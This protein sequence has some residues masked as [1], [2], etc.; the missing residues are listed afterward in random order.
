MK[1][2]IADHH[3]VFRPKAKTMKTIYD[4]RNDT[5]FVRFTETAI[6]E[7]EEISPGLILD[8][9]VDGRIVALEFL[10]ASKKI[11]GEATLKDSQPEPITRHGLS[12]PRSPDELVDIVHPESVRRIVRPAFVDTREDVVV[13][14][15]LAVGVDIDHGAVDLEQRDHLLDMRVDDEGVGLARRLVDVRTFGRDPVVLEIAPLAFEH[16]AVHRQRMAVAR[17]HAGF[18]HLEQVHP[19]AARG[20]HQE[21]AEPD[22][23]LD[24]H[25]DALVGRNGVR[26]DEFRRRFLRLR[27]PVG[28][29]FVVSLGGLLRLAHPKLPKSSR[30]ERSGEPGPTPHP[31]RHGSRIAADAASGTTPRRIESVTRPDT[32]RRPRG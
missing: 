4:E 27:V 32:P 22:V 24:R 31:R 15:R 7:S 28:L 11:A 26:D 17:Q 10:N 6:L 14:G 2:R 25:P 5:L 8:Y 1:A 16:E 30:P 20:A 29:P 12:T 19:V 3:R 9:D 23:L 13:A 21:R 18:L